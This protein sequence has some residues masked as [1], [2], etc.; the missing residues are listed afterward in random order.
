MVAKAS[1]PTAGCDHRTQHMLNTHMSNTDHVRQ[2]F[3]MGRRLQSVHSSRKLYSLW[4]SATQAQH[5]LPSLPNE[6]P[7]S[8]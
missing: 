6:A 7:T 8:F 3:T 4:K 1:A 5:P 2:M